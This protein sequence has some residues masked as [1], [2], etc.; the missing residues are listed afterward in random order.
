MLTLV[1]VGYVEPM[2][3]MVLAVPVVQSVAGGN[4]PLFIFRKVRGDGVAR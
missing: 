1:A 3:N 2:S 4:N